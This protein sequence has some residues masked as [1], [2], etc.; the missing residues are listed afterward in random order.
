MWGEE[1]KK[2]KARIQKV[3]SSNLAGGSQKLFFSKLFFQAGFLIFSGKVS[4]VL[5]VLK[6]VTVRL[7]T[8][9]VR[10]TVKAGYGNE[11]QKRKKIEEKRNKRKKI[12]EEKRNK[13]KKGKKG[14]KS[15]IVDFLKILNWFFEVYCFF[16]DLK[17]LGERK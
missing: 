17:K 7:V 2:G 15:V 3:A 16:E 12:E 9:K 8:V 1:S 4:K 14:E 13:R 5:K 6:L 11:K 10:V